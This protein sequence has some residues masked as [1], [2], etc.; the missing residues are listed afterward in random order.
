MNI[1]QLVELIQLLDV[2]HS[3]DYI[4][5]LIEFYDLHQLHGATI[6]SFKKVPLRDLMCLVEHFRINLLKDRF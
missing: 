3:K 6:S 2:H 1:T 5:S 4:I